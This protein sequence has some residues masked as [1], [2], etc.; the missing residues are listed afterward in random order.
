MPFTIQQLA[1]EINTDPVG[2]G[3]AAHITAGR[4]GE[5]ARILNSTR[6]GVGQVWRDDLRGAEVLGALVWSEIASLSTN[7]WLALQSLLIPS[8]PI[9]ASNVRIRNIFGGLFPAGSFPQTN[10][11]LSAIGQ[12]ASPSRAEELWGYG[13]TVTPEDVIRALRTV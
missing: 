5:L 10:A 11:N 8:T 13:T 2:L 1:T 7:S 4:M 3:Y 9:D 12:K 6:T